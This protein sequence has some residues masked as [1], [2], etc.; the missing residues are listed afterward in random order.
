[1]FDF[2]PQRPIPQEQ[3]AT[4]RLA[5]WTLM[6]DVYRDIQLPQTLYHY[7]DAG[8]LKGIVESGLLRATH[9]AFM[10]DASEYLHA[11]SLLAREID[12]ALLS[13][14]DPLRISLLK[15]VKDPVSLAGPQHVGPYFVSCLSS[16]ENSLNQWRA[17]GRGEGGYSIGFDLVKLN[18][19]VLGLDGVLAPVIY[20]PSRQLA[21]VQKLLQWGLSE[22]Q[23]VAATIP[24]NDRDEH[25]RDWAHMFLWRATAAAPLIKNPAFVEEREWRIIFR[26][27]WKEQVR[28]LPR[29]TGLAPFV[30]LKLGAPAAEISSERLKHL[31]RAS[32]PDRLPITKLWSGPGR[33]TDTSLLAGRTLLEQ[34]GY[35]GVS[36]EASKIPFRVG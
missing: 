28:L 1:M 14:S 6:N 23:K 19:D 12:Q 13:E 8:G 15:E 31:G 2:V 33:A 7:T 26:P 3:D 35:D 10:N 20:E 36:L 9:L 22:Y 4:I 27:A 34:M 11:V 18:Q 29:S 21:L 5:V 24:I 16:E 32:L 25:R 30:E 17:Y